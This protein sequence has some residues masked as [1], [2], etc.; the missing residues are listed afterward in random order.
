MF[1]AFV[2]LV[3]LV[4]VVKLIKRLTDDKNKS[5]LHQHSTALL[6]TAHPD[7]ECMF[8]APTILEL[9][10]AAINM[11]LLCL[12]TG[13]FYGLGKT[14]EKELVKSCVVLGIPSENCTAIDDERFPDDP[15]AT[16]DKDELGY[17]IV[18]KVRLTGASLVICFDSGGVSGHPNHIATYKAVD[19]IMK[20]L[21]NVAFYK[22][23][24]LSIL[25]K[26]IGFLDI[27]LS[28]ISATGE[29]KHHR[30][31]LTPEVVCFISTWRQFVSAL[32]A[33]CKH[34]SQLMWF[35]VLYVLFSRY[36][37][38]NTLVSMRNDK[39]D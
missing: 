10:Q 30:G 29:T 34:W 16:W 2:I 31:I 39:L 32:W 5:F 28:F 35:R 33:M 1:A 37:I 25:R 6:V 8:F 36:M 7:D 27:F 3:S 9:R 19:S 4:C 20:K 18:D 12:S 14:R 23:V 21:E 26:Y 22:L 17:I 15:K 11:H 38:V 13:G 24:S